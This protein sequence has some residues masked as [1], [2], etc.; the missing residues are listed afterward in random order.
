MPG[1]Y[2]YCKASGGALDYWGICLNVYDEVAK[3]WTH[4]IVSLDGGGTRYIRNKEIYLNETYSCWT[5]IKRI[6]CDD[7]KLMIEEIQNEN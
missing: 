1:D 3:S 6:K 2:V 5:L 4:S 7:V